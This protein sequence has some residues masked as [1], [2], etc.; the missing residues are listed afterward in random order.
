MLIFCS[1]LLNFIDLLSSPIK[2]L[3]KFSRLFSDCALN[4]R[5]KC[6]LWFICSHS[7]NDIFIYKDFPFMYS[8]QLIL[9]K[10]IV[11]GILYIL[12]FI[13]ATFALFNSLQV[14]NICFVSFVTDDGNKI[15]IGVNLCRGFYVFFL[16]FLI[17]CHY[18]FL[19]LWD[20]IYRVGQIFVGPWRSIFLLAHSFFLIFCINFCK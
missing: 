2:F 10:F 14:T 7:I 8:Q 1:P 11:P 3:L 12:P 6:L 15:P 17:S 9:F 5:D 16:I 19:F 13:R 4:E 18:L 20:L